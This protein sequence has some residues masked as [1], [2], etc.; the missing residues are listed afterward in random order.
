M[1]TTL[2]VGEIAQW[3]RE[4]AALQEDLSSVPSIHMAPRN[5]LQL[6]FQGI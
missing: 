3:L 2:E 4:L 1:K 6:Q 5:C